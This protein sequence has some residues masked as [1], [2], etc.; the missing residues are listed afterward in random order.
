VNTR[1]LYL[2]LALTLLAGAPVQAEPAAQL[3]RIN[4]SSKGRRDLV[5]APVMRKAITTRITATAIIEPNAGAVAE[6]TSEIPARVVK[7]VAQPGER[8]EVGEPLAIVSSVE[9]GQ[10]KTEYL[11]ARS[12][13]GL[14]AQHLRRE[15]D[16]YAKKITPMKDLLEARGQHDAA[17]AEYKAARE[18]LRLLIPAGQ[19]SKLQWSDNGQPLSEFPLTA[20]IA[21]TLVKRNRSIGAMIDR[22]GPAPLMI[23]NLEHVWVIASVFEH[24]L[25][26]LKIGAE[27]TVTADAYSDRVFSGRITYIGD[28]VDRSTR[29]IRTRIE[30]SNP[31]HSLKPGMF[32][33][34]SIVA[35]NSR[36][37]LMVPESAIYQIDG[38]LVAFVAAGNNGFEVRPVQIGSRGDGAVEVLSGLGQDEVVVEKGGLTLKSLIANKE[39]D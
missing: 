7:L 10:A 26:S 32:A 8:L 25:A 19:I 21:G 18:R 31:D 20:P 13:E 34:A 23:I 3:L 30:V 5:L 36:E 2:V 37:V 17:L 9:L 38:R 28:E 15:T 35:G 16:L 6:V 29:A 4:V 1:L 39:A 12:L 33:K 27:V 22:N 24:D 14:S 11:K